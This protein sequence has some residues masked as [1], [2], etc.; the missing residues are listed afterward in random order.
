VENMLIPLPFVLS[1]VL[2]SN[3][4]LHQYWYVTS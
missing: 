1:W 4:S 2:V 3:G